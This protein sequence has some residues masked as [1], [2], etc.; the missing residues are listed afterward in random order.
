[1]VGLEKQATRL[2]MRNHD[3]V[4]HRIY[5]SMISKAFIVRK[6]PELA[7]RFVK[8]LFPNQAVTIDVYDRDSEGGGSSYKLQVTAIPANHCPGSVM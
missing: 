7:E 1:M 2:R 6:Y 8:D 5:C 3:K 4:N